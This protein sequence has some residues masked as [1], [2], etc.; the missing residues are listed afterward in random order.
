MIEIPFY[1]DNL[2]PDVIKYLGKYSSPK[3]CVKLPSIKKFLNIIVVPAISEYQ[4]IKTL[5]DCLMQSDQKYYE[6]TLVLFVINAKDES[7][8]DVKADNSKSID[9]LNNFKPVGK[10]SIGFIDAATKGFSM[11]DKEGGVGLARKIGMDLALTL[12]NYSS[13]RKKLIIC[14]DADCIVNKN[15]LTEIV[16]YFNNE[17]VSAAVV[18][19]GHLLPENEDEKRGIISYEI[20]LRYYIAGLF[21][22]GSPFAYHSVGSTMVC[23]YESYIKV[24][25][26][27]KRK[28]AEDF[29]FLEKLAKITEIKKIKSTTVHPSSRESWRVPFGTGQRMNRFKAGTH[30]EYLLFDPRLFDLLKEWLEIFYGPD[31]LSAAGYIQKAEGI[32]PEISLFLKQNMFENQWDAII[33]NS[34]NPDQIKKQ[35][36]IW[37]DGFRTMKLV[38]HIRDNVYPLINMFDALDLLFNRMNYEI[39]LKRTDAIPSIEVQLEYLKGLRIINNR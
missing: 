38:H 18:E 12:F 25:G 23:D 4:N 16:D 17:E 20:F 24:G 7:P 31:F 6:S 30:N 39:I 21:Y 2:P 5:L 27:N 19:Y 35:K 32:H 1:P 15:Y 26:M 14:L 9:Y 11:P 28:A 36:M 34:R 22:A 13:P 8:E 10:L 33:S 3:W 29:Y 37:F